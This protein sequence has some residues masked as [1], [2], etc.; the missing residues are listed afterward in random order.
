MTASTPGVALV[1]TVGACRGS[2]GFALAVGAGGVV[3]AAATSTLA[4]RQA[5]QM[6]LTRRGMVQ[7]VV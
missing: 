1:T 2:A 6:N 3:S 4:V 7:G 5:T